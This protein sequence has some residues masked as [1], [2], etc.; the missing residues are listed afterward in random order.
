VTPAIFLILVAVLLVLLAGNRPLEA[1]LGAAI[2]ALG[3]PAYW[4]AFRRRLNPERMP[5]NDLDT[6]D[7]T[8]GSR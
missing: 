5:S 1:A 3:L 8:A 7:P 2:V 6:H 4:L